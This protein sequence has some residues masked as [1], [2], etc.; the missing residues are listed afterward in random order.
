MPVELRSDMIDVSLLTL[1]N[2]YRT[3]FMIYEADSENVR[4]KISSNP[5]KFN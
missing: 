5:I 2:G 1:D 4:L 3:R